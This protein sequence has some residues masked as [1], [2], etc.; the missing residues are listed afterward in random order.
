[1]TVLKQIFKEVPED[2]NL[3]ILV[4]D[5]QKNSSIFDE[6]KE[7]PDVNFVNV[8]LELSRKLMHSRIE[9]ITNPQYFFDEILKNFNQE[10]VIFYN[11]DILFDSNLEFNP[12]DI[13]KKISAQRKIICIWNGSFSDNKLS[14]SIYSHSDYFSQ[15]VDS[16]E[17]SIIKTEEIE[18]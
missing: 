1:M 10:R 16:K 7:S 11:I 9:T 6:L 18:S 8:G 13:F 14:Y 12:L 4:G 17:A 2:T 15:S 3:I 5:S